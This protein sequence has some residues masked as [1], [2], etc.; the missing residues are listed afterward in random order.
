[1]SRKG[2]AVLVK[3]LEHKCFKEQLGKLGLFNLEKRRLRGD[4]IPLQLPERRE[5]PGGGLALFSVTGKVD[6]NQ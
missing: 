1:M 3:G 4:L 5:Q 2:P 6:I